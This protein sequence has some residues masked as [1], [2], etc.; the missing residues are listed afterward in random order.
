MNLKFKTKFYPNRTY[1][2]LLFS[3]IASMS[4]CSDKDQLKNQ[5]KKEILSDIG[6]NNY[7]VIMGDGSNFYGEPISIGRD[8]YYIHH[9]TLSCPVIKV[10]VQRNWYKLSERNNTFC[11][12]CMNDNL[13]TMFHKRFFSK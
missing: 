12:V 8:D 7:Q 11:H 6:N 4:S 5:I 1:F 13:I 3:I 9:S 10:G 2:I